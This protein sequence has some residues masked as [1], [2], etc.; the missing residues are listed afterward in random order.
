MSSSRK[1]IA[2]A[3]YLSLFPLYLRGSVTNFT[4][5][6]TA[7][8]KGEIVTY[9]PVTDNNPPLA[10]SS[11]KWE[12]RYNGQCITDWVVAQQGTTPTVT[13]YESRPGKWDVRLT[14]TYAPIMSFPPV[15]PPPT[16]ITKQ[17]S[18]AP[19]TN[20]VITEGLNSSYS[21]STPIT[22]KFRLM[23][24]SK[25]CG[26]MLSG[27]AQELITDR[28]LLNPPLG[29][30]NPVSDTDWNPSESVPGIFWLQGNEI[31]DVKNQ[32]FDPAKWNQIPNNTSYYS[33]VQ[34]LRFKY[35][36]PCGIEQVI[37]L[38]QFNLSRTKDANGNWYLSA[39]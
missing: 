15:F 32:N 20:V 22:I 37:S 6:S 2:L 4:Y 36:D 26:P 24:G 34:S 18:I 8:V 19:A 17:V 1:C 9:T 27:L 5:E 38:G 21:A 16:V 3:L 10:I 35:I 30:P 14:V 23:S 39:Q 33:C 13:F 25:P 29:N 7:P 12:Y 28:V 11:Y 31:W